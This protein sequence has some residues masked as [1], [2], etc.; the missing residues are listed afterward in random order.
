MFD[1][2]DQEIS[3]LGGGQFLTEWGIA[4]PDA[5]RPE[6]WGTQE[7]LWVMERADRQALSWCYWDTS[8]LGVLWHNNNT[9]IQSAVSV[10]SRPYPLAVAG[11]EPN[12]SFDFKTK[13]FH[14]EFYPD[15]GITAPSLIFLPDHIYEGKLHIVSSEELSVGVSET[16]SQVLQVTLKEGTFQNTK[17]SWVTVGVSEEIISRN[18]SWMDFFLS[19]IPILKRR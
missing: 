11:K 19:Y 7:S 6:Y 17:K 13:T 8:N 15:K 14:L 1:G 10:L 2:A 4:V 18:D 5:S 3:R 16:N 9:K 12:Y